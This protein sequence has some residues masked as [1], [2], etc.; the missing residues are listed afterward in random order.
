MN[1]TPDAF[2]KYYVA[3]FDLSKATLY[4]F[5]SENPYDY[6]PDLYYEWYTELFYDTYGYEVGEVIYEDEATGVTICGDEVMSESEFAV[7]KSSAKTDDYKLTGYTAAS[8]VDYKITSSAILT[9]EYTKRNVGGT[10][11]STVETVTGTYTGEY[12]PYE[13]K[14]LVSIPVDTKADAIKAYTSSGLTE[15]AVVD[16][17]INV[18]LEADNTITIVTYTKSPDEVIETPTTEENPTTTAT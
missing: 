16:G 15:A 6:R 4:K 3:D 13:G 11:G 17:F 1:I 9:T 8:A 12:I 18:E 5:Y 2:N 7:E 10:D 14:I